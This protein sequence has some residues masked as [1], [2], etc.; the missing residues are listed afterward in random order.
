MT[1]LEGGLIIAFLGERQEIAQTGNLLAKMSPTVAPAVTANEYAETYLNREEAALQNDPAP[2]NFSPC[3]FLNRGCCTIYPVRPFGCRSFNSII[4]CPE[5]DMAEVPPLV[6]TVNAVCMQIIEHLDSDGGL[7]GNMADV[8]KVLLAGPKRTEEQS[9]LLP[10]RPN[11]GFLVPP[12]ERESVGN[13]I[14]KLNA[15]FANERS[16]TGCYK[17]TSF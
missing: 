1:T 4:P 10:A 17:K 15:F 16:G 3:I 5:N 11:P 12:S 7:W 9:R 2:W 6:I 8:L 14:Y 13:F